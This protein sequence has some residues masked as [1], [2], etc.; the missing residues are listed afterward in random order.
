M[1]VIAC[2]G[3]A[4][5]NFEIGLSTLLGSAIIAFTLI[6]GVVGLT[7]PE[8]LSLRLAPQMRNVV[9]FVAA[10]EMLL[11]DVRDDQALHPAEAR[12]LA[13]VQVVFYAVVCLSGTR[14]CARLGMLHTVTAQPPLPASPISRSTTNHRCV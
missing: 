4:L 6:P 2:I 13:L 9:F 3:V 8:P 12:V 1:Q 7:I 11:R 10:L 5:G 14:L